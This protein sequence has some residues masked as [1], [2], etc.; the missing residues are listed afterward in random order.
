MP[1]Y[2]ETKTGSRWTPCVFPYRPE[3]K[4][5]NGGTR[6]VRAG[7]VGP[8]VRAVQEI[9]HDHENLTLSQLREVYG[10]GGKFNNRVSEAIA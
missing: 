6:L 9:A 1:F 3:E 5:I 2:A 7:S 8:R 4:R 10:T